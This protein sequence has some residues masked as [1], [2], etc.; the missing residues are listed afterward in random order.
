MK[1]RT[2]KIIIETVICALAG[3]AF[4]VALALAF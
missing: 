1:N 4:G 3:V 2:A